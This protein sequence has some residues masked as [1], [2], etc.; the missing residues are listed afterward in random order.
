[1]VLTEKQKALQQSIRKTVQKIIVPRAEDID[2]SNQF[3]EDVVKALTKEGY[4]KTRVPKEYG[5]LDWGTLE[6]NL[7]IEEISRASGSMAMIWCTSAQSA[8]MEKLFGTEAQKKKY[9]TW[10]ANDAIAN[11][12]ASSEPSGG[13]DM[14]GIQTTAVRKGDYYIL[15]GDKYF[16]EPATHADFFHVFAK[17]EPEKRSRGISCF[18]VEKNFPGV[19]IGKV[20]DPIGLRGAGLAEILLRDAKVP[21]ENLLGPYNAGVRIARAGLDDASAIGGLPLGMAQ[22]ALEL[23]LDYAVSRKAFDQT[24]ASFQ[25]V[26]F[27]LVDMATKVEAS[28]SMIYRASG[29]R[30]A[31][32]NDVRFFV[33]SSTFANMVAYEVSQSALDIFGGHGVLDNWHPVT[34]VWRDAHTNYGAG[35]TT[36]LRR[37]VISRNMFTELSPSSP[38]SPFSAAIRG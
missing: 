7:L 16:L 34:R 8:T 9:L 30:D 32:Q 14:G 18:I 1:M 25:A 11:Y 5:G 20:A 35:G 3:P 22:S 27:M 10:L 21:A 17:T 12:A 15:S 13:T 26:N 33:M 36:N 38:L 2:R 6:F 28:R 29:I 19:S 31:G 4:M 24:I 23:A 37:L